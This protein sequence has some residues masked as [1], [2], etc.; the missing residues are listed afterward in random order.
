MVCIVWSWDFQHGLIGVVS[1]GVFSSLQ[2]LLIPVWFASSDYILI[3]KRCIFQPLVL[4]KNS[5]LSLCYWYWRRSYNI[6]LEGVWVSGEC[7]TYCCTNGCAQIIIFTQGKFT[8]S[9]LHFMG[10]LFFRD[11][12]LFGCLIK[13]NSSRTTMLTYCILF[14]GVLGFLSIPW[15]PILWNFLSYWIRDFHFSFSIPLISDRPFFLVP[16]FFLLG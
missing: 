16:Y 7:L 12:V 2:I 5:W 10:V 9:Y 11:I 3:F 15:V 14:I 4:L 1:Q 13:W 8:I 6:F